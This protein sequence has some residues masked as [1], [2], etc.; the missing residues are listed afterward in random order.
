MKHIGE[1]THEKTK[2]KNFQRANKRRLVKEKKRATRRKR[3][4]KPAT[5]S[6]EMTAPLRSLDKAKTE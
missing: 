2:P 6:Y 3:K 5:K 4:K 1:S